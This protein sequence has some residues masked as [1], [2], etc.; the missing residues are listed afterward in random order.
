ML[1]Y[2]EVRLIRDVERHAREIMA[3]FDDLPRTQRDRENYREPKQ[4]MPQGKLKFGG[5][6]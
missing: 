2:R 4:P 3:G 1:F 5:P 6:A